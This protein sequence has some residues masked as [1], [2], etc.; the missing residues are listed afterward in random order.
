[1]SVESGY[2]DGSGGVKLHYVHQGAGPLLLLLHGFPD[3]WFSWRNQIPALAKDHHVVAIDLRGYNESDKPDGVEPYRMRHLCDD[4]DAVIDQLGGGRATLVGHDWGGA[5]AWSYA[6][7]HPEK[8][9]ALVILNAPHPATFPRAIR[10]PPQLFRSWYV[11]FF[12]LPRVPEWALTRSRAGAIAGVFKDAAR[13][14]QVEVYRSRFLKPGVA[15][16]ALNYYRATMRG[17]RDGARQPFHLL[18]VPT[19]LIWGE[20][21]V[22]LGKELTFGLDRYVKNLRIEYV[23]GAGH[24]V[25]QEQPA[26]VNGLLAE[27]LAKRKPKPA[28]RPA[29]T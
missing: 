19:L 22:A 11:F 20:N 7:S 23:P 16:A 29:K 28:R 1:M 18:E 13:P 17:M 6:Y 27:F 12:Q 26:L 8:L 4:V 24:F 10:K 14:D 21:D 25:H 9:D 2:V 15:T 5:V 3:F